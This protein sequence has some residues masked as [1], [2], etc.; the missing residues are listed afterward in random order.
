MKGYIV[1]A[2]YKIEDNK[3]L[4]HLFGR[5]ENGESF[6]ATT[7]YKPYFYIKSIDLESAKNILNLEYEDTE[8]KNFE[9]QN[10]T[11]VYVDIPSDISDVKR[12]FE[13]SN[14]GNFEADIGFIQRYFID[15]DI[16]GIIDLEGDYEKGEKVNRKYINP[17][18][19]SVDPFNIKIKTLAIDI[20][21]DKNI[22]QIYS[23]SLVCNDI[24]EVHIVTRK[25]VQD[26][27]I[28][29]SELEMLQG[30]VKRIIEIDPDI[31]TGWN[32]IDFDLK[33]I[34]RRLKHFNIPFT[35]GRNDKPTY[36]RIQEDFFR[37]S[38]AK[39]PGRIVFDGIALLKQAFLSYQDYK[40]DTVAKEV[41]GKNKVELEP[42]FWNNFIE[43]VK[44]E[45]EKVV[46][47]NLIDSVLVIEILEKLNLIDL[48]IKK[49]L[50]TGL[51]LDRVKG[52]I[53][54]LDSLYLRESKKRGIVCPNSSFGERE[55]RIKG[56]Y[57]MEP[58]P[59]IYDYVAVLDFKSLYPSIIRTYNI[60]PI[61]FNEQGTIIAPNGARFINE[62]G[63]LP[64]IIKELW[65]E[66]D[67]AKKEK[68]D[69]K[70]YAVKIIMNSFYG[71]L[72][73][74]T[75]RFYSL[76]MGNAIT[77]FARETIKETEKLIEE[78]GYTVLYGDTDSVF[79]DFKAKDVIEAQKL[80]EETSEFINKYFTKLVKEKFDRESILE[81][82]FEKMFKVLMLPR[83]RGST[84]GAKKR[85]AGL[86]IKN[87]K[88]EIK[89]TGMEIVRRDWT[90]IAKEMQWEL[91]D[92][93]FHKKEV[94][95]YIKK[96]V[97]E[98]KNGKYDDKLVYRKSI[99]KDLKEYVKTTP[100]HVKAA[101]LLPK[102][103]SSIIEYIITVNGPEPLSISK[104]SIDY[105][106]YIEKQ[107]KPIA[108]TILNLFN[109]NFDDVISGAKQK[110][111]FD[112]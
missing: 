108:E 4:I 97:E 39:I 15:N 88:E 75:C 48:M 14:I 84:S 7:K 96:I 57:V 81:L 55:E 61:S 60:D 111:L 24:K 102:L 44:N 25:Q 26:A 16:S 106:H 49:S 69:V 42:D 95:N 80:A 21:T 86:L 41:L 23:I 32:V 110:S 54:A 91:L 9:K 77:A 70:S 47:Y 28:Y 22:K 68:D 27:I 94:A 12:T 1:E 98:I 100:P 20:E 35:V 83:G 8:L 11:K 19:K 72:A 59:G 82:E 76:E 29:N 53:A 89:V 38:N 56:A 50:I 112:Y 103:T 87:G 37:D 30:V 79:V 65:K 40:L 58:K 73:N 74:P 5:L 64:G 18:I 93:V 109:T 92:R 99:R 33:V 46:K 36:I 6:H 107:I 62:K 17:V 51:P 71:V 3:P 101:R 63:I 66:R 104:S 67:I 31:V 10:L 90:D 85:Y 52:S 13:T 34:Q 78:K 43:I 45:P 105:E 2:S